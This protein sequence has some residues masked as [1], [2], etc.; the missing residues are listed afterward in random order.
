MNKTILILID[1]LR[2]D[3]IA[4]TDTPAMDDLMETGT[5]CLT[6]Q[7]VEPSLTLPVHFSIFTS[8]PPYS[9]GVLTNTAA[10]DMSGTA[11]SLFAHIKAQGGT[12]AAFYS[13]D[14]LRNLA[15][16]GQVDYTLVHRVASQ[17]DL[18]VLGAA[19]ARHLITHRPDFIFLYLE[20]ADLMGHAHAWMSG[21][22]LSAVTQC[23]HVL[24]KLVDAVQTAGRKG[25]DFNIVVLSD[26]GGRERH[27]LRAHPDTLTIPFIAHGRSVRSGVCLDRK[28]SVL[29]IAP[30]IAKLM[31]ITP[32]PG[33]QGSIVSECVKTQIKKVPMIH[34]G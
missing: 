6:G 7:T 14:H 4:Q 32:H 28:I 15:L 33:W 31:D 24:G 3:A 25:M 27:H 1:G 17:K 13:W 26:H 34:L 23:D 22:Y 5:V 11:Q 19:A 20:W 9:H 8:L 29:D 18:D 21:P 30:T 12:T 16:P 2:S 10:P